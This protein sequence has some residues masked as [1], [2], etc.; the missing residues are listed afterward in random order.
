LRIPLHRLPI[1]GL[2][3]IVVRLPRYLRLAGRLMLDRRVPLIPKIVLSAVIVYV[4]S[5]FDLIPEAFFPPVG[6]A[7]DVV[8]FLVSVH[9]LIKYS[10]PDVVKEHALA[11]EAG[12]SRP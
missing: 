7:E 5:P 6:L 8:F 1:R 3:S 9:N 11:I 12:R 10:P 2:L 4:V